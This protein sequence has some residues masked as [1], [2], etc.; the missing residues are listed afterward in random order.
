MDDSHKRS[1]G[2][3]GFSKRGSSLS[4][5]EPIHEN[6]N[7][8]YCSRLGCSTRLNSM[9]AP[10]LSTPEKPKYQRTSFRSMSNKSIAG[11]SSKPFS[12]STEF[13]K[14]LKSRPNHAS[15]RDTIETSSSRHR[16]TEEIESNGET[17]GSEFNQSITGIQTVLPESE[18][19][20]SQTAQGSSSSR[21][22]KQINTEN[23]SSSSP[24]RHPIANKNKGQVI[25]P[26]SQ[27]LGSGPPRYGLK[28]L[29]CSSISDVLPSRCSSSDSGQSRRV[30]SVRKR[31]SDGESASSRGKSSSESSSSGLSAT[32]RSLMPQQ[33]SR[34]ARNRGLSRD[35]PVSV[36][37][38]RASGGQQRENV[39]SVS[40]PPVY[41]QL[42]H[43]QIT[44]NEVVPESSSRSFPVEP[45]PIF[46]SSFGGRPSSSWQSSRS[47]LV[48]PRPED[49]SIHATLGDRDGYRGFNM[50]GIAEV[51]LALERIEQDDELTYEQ[52][53]VLE[54][55]L[56]LGGFS[57]HD[58][59]RDMRLDIDNM[60]YEDLLALEEKMGTVS[61]ALS[62]EALA[63]CLKRSSYVPACQVPGVST[64]GEDDVKCS[65]CQEDYV[66]GDEVGKLAC[67]HRYHVEC[68]SQWL[69]QKNW[70][71]ICKSSATSS[72]APEESKEK[73]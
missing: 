65:I 24:I 39:I 38:R 55:N 73:D 28:N 33:N 12:G 59:H 62:E 53:M 43:T 71:P 15:P 16:V 48:N 31:P 49:T 3:F 8:Q 56:F 20:K 47:R 72:H 25:R 35:G 63:K 29:G 2:G 11:S 60:S 34:R 51:L 67:D 1:A 32:N 10:E 21:L 41:P 14:P 30:S 69:R 9:K 70:C 13:R 64:H 57:F 46:R 7:I 68:I 5:R 61:T 58:Q 40:E 42:P 23:P 17:E 26:S 37:T 22:Q 50:D 44:I 45:H 27:Y 36:R 66:I 4:F 18:D 54:T 52:L 6:K 19:I